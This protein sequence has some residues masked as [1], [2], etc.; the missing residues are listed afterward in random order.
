MDAGR[1]LPGTPQEW[2]ALVAS[3]F[4]GGEDNMLIVSE[5]GVAGRT[6]FT[7]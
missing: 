3:G 6:R 2:L 5:A 4:I 7:L 1:A